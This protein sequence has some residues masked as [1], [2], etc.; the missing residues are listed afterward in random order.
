MILLNFPNT[1]LG[2]DVKSLPRAEVEDFVKA[3]V[4]HSLS[5][6]RIGGTKPDGIRLSEN[7][8]LSR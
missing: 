5:S 8:E 1:S 3:N 7:S 6:A 4:S 2:E